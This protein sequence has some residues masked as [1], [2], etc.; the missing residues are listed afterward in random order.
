MKKAKAGYVPPSIKAQKRKESRSPLFLVNILLY[1]ICA[2]VAVTQA[3]PRVSAAQELIGA[4]RV[5]VP[6]STSQSVDLTPDS[7]DAFFDNGD[8]EDLAIEDIEEPTVVRGLN[9]EYR[10]IDASALAG[11]SDRDLG[12]WYLTQFPTDGY[13]NKTAKAEFE[14]WL[15]GEVTSGTRTQSIFDETISYLEA[16]PEIVNPPVVEEMDNPPIEKDKTDDGSDPAGSDL[17][18]EGSSSS[19][20]V[21][22]PTPATPGVVSSGDTSSST[23]GSS[24]NTGSTTASTTS[25]INTEFLNSATAAE[26][27]NWVYTTFKPGSTWDYAALTEFYNWLDAKGTTDGKFKTN[28]LTYLD[29]MG[30]TE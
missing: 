1:A 21:A 30:W 7:G 24:G 19:G 6:A 23:G 5:S 20:Y 15:E 4:T 13:Y 8:I 14:D 27:A 10:Y 11:M 2:V 25:K 29:I 12:I 28:V 3:M 16:H 26:T 18:S 22:P 17:S 9:G